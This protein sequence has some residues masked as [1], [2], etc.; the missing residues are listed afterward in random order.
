MSEAQLKATILFTLAG[1]FMKLYD[2]TMTPI[3]SKMYRIMK[4]SLR[5]VYE[6]NKQ[7]YVDMVKV[8][9]KVWQEVLGEQKANLEIMTLVS[10]I[11]GYDDEVAKKFGI[12][13][14]LVAKFQNIQTDDVLV[15]VELRSRNVAN[16]L[17]EG[18]Y[19]ELGLEP[20]KNKLSTLKK[21]LEFNKVLENG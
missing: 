6:S 18:C 12:T 2:K 7:E 1:G 15:D 13:P 21:T 14:K 17:I 11:L 8:T 20:R 5:K 9:D 3:T 4:K 10:H 19:K 16:A